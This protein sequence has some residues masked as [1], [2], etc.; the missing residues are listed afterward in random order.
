MHS[1]H[2]R[3]TQGM[4]DGCRFVEWWSKGGLH[5]RRTPRCQEL[6]LAN[7]RGEAE[8]FDLVHC[9]GKDKEQLCYMTGIEVSMPLN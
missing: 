5:S 7:K 2:E 4:R 9:A 8:W 3:F 1:L 6:S